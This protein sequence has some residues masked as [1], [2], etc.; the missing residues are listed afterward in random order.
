VRKGGI[1]GRGQEEK[2]GREE[3]R[4]S[5]KAKG[6]VERGSKEREEIKGRVTRE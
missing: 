3:T 4:R 5:E 2:E 1:R 6:S